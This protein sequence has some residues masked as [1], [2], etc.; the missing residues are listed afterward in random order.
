[1]F[2]DEVFWWRLDSISRTKT[3]LWWVQMSEMQKKMD[4]R[5]FM[6]KYWSRMCQMSYK[7]I[8]VQTGIFAYI[9]LTSIKYILETDWKNWKFSKWDFERASYSATFSIP[10]KYL[11]WTH[12]NHFSEPTLPSRPY[13]N[14]KSYAKSARVL[15][16][17]AERKFHQP[18]YLSSPYDT[19]TAGLLRFRKRSNKHR[20]GLPYNLQL[21]YLSTTGL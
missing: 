11:G 3:V 15:V 13:E 12:R 19:R 7:C 18:Y 16:I 8:P 2:L 9:F 10:Q 5:Q 6:V 4:V 20:W 17:I 21:I 14:H 1:M